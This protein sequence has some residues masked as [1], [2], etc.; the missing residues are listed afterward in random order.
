M[1]TDRIIRAIARDGRVRVLTCVTTEL[2]RT[3]QKRHDTWPVAT[4]ALGRTASISA[5]MAMLLKNEE[6]LTVK[7]AGDGPVGQ[8][9]VEALPNGD[10]RGYVDNPYVDLPLNAAGKLD[11]GGAVGS[12]HLYVIR[13]TGLRDYYTSSSELQS[14]EIADDF[15]YYFVTSEQT[16][17]AVGA[18]VLVDTDDAPIVAGGFLV[19]LMPDHREEDIAYIEEGLQRVPSVTSFLESHTS[20]EALLHE[21][22]PDAQILA[23]QD[24]RFRCKC[25]YERIKRILL[26][27]GADELASIRKEQG[28]A[29]VTCHFC[30][31]VYT[32][33]EEELESMIA[34]LQA[35]VEETGE[36]TV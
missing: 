19:Q 3:L 21:L 33:E 14:G 12:G 32:F 4:A 10:V 29:E 34:T 26:S 2:V 18:G 30:G 6:S 23:M 36:G 17:S 27:L 8:I 11:V 1:T 13:D 7:V 15:T 25:S 20:A 31:N 9:W 22:C 35:S 16:P 28:I 5:M 24:V